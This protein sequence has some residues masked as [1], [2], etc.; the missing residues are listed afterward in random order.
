MKVIKLSKK[1]KVEAV[2]IPYDG[3]INLVEVSEWLG[4]ENGIRMNDVVAG[5]YIIKDYTFDTNAVDIITEE[6]LNRQYN[7]MNEALVTELLC[8]MIDHYRDLYAAPKPK[9][10]SFS[11]RIDRFIRGHKDDINTTYWSS[12]WREI[13]FDIEKK[14]ENYNENKTKVDDR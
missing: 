11:V 5:S 12:L 8:E 4:S 14:R 7:R 2:Q 1:S 13:K 6:E 3:N 9:L 10:D